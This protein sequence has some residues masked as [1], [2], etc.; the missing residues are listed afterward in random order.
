VGGC[1]ELTGGVWLDS[2]GVLPAPK[3]SGDKF[4]GTLGHLQVKT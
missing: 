3:W 1:G 2:E 4:W